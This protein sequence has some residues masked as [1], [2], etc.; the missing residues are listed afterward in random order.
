VQNDLNLAYQ[1]VLGR[2]ADSGGL[3][4]YEDA[5]AAGNTLANL[6]TMLAQSPEA[7]NDLN[8]L[9]LQVLGRDGDNGGLDTY[10]SLLAQGGSLA[11]VREI[12][13]HSGEAQ[14]DI[15]LIYQQ[16]LGRAA[17]NGGLA[18]YEDT[19]DGGWSL[20]GVRSDIAHSAEAQA[21]LVRLFDGTVNRDPNAAELAGAETR[22]T[23]GAAL[24]DL[25]NDLAQ[26]GSAGGFTALAATSGD[27]SL[28][29]AQ[30]PTAFLFSDVAFGQDT[31]S[32]FDPSQDAIVLGHAQAPG[33]AVSAD[34]AGTLV[35]LNPSQSIQLNGV[36]PAALHPSNF[37]FV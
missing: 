6:R 35:T 24:S 5:L 1:Q 30:G 10:T 29:A 4:A 2:N 21:D 27:A 33:F 34:A 9:Y 16:V 20:A 19:L 8:Q 32:G 13:G 12:L 25:G 26:S 28:S 36:S 11:G 22:L 7:Q 15:A 17:D 14:N 23:Q 18:T 3:A 31:I 37:Q